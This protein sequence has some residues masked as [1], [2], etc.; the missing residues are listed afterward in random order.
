MAAKWCR[1]SISDVV[2]PL[3]SLVFVPLYACTSGYISATTGPW[4]DVVAIKHL[5]GA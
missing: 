4:G 1:L 5:S 2:G 3:Q